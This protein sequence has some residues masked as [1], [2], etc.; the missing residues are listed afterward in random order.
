MNIE[1]RALFQVCERNNVQMKSSENDLGKDEF[2]VTLVASSSR[3]FVYGIE[4]HNDTI[5]IGTLELKHCCPGTHRWSTSYLTFAAASNSQE[6]LCHMLNGG[7]LKG[8]NFIMNR[9]S[10]NTSR[11]DSSQHIISFWMHQGDIPV[12]PNTFYSVYVYSRRD[13][14]VKTICRWEVRIFVVRPGSLEEVC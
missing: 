6:T 9:G 14:E 5:S 8:K 13:P 1:D 7:K 4:W 11:L 2:E 10:F 3:E 12:F